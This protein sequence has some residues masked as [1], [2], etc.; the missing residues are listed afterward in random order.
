MASTDATT[1]FR[2]AIGIGIGK[3]NNVLVEAEATLDFVVWQEVD[4]DTANIFTSLRSTRILIWSFAVTAGFL[5]IWSYRYEMPT[6]D[7]LSYLAIARAYE[8]HDWQTAINS[9]W[10]PL[11]PWLLLLTFWITDASWY[12][13]STIVHFLN[14][15]IYV[16]A[17]VCFAVFFRELTAI[18]R[19]PNQWPPETEG[20]SAGAWLDWASRLART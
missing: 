16:S 8:R 13:E 6:N 14:F 17:L 9:F 18:C 19:E 10:S 4:S 2:P 12:W 3:E 1:G 11:Y 15:I 5:R 20:F 7:C